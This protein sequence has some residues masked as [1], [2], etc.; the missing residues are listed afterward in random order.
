MEKKQMFP[1]AWAI[2]DLET[3]VTWK[4]FIKVLK[5]DLDLGNGDKVIIVTNMPKIDWNGESGFE[6]THSEYRH[7]VDLSREKCTYRSWEIICISCPHATCYLF[8]KKLKSEDYISK[9]YTKEYYLKSYAYTM[10]LVRAM[11][12][13]EDSENPEINPLII[14]KQ[15]SRPKKAKRKD[16]DEVPQVRIS[17]HESQGSNVPNTINL[18]NTAKQVTASVGRNATSKFIPHYKLESQVKNATEVTGDLGFKASHLDG[19]ESK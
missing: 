10:Q 15:P 5:Q 8:H 4:W 16:K 3:K 9:Y 19:R 6:I 18:P 14:T 17:Q 7:I 2:I 12:L 1:I 11:R 13:G